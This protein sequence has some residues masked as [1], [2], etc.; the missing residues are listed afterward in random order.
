MTGT[1]K[2][3]ISLHCPAPNLQHCL[4]MCQPE[5]LRHANRSVGKLCRNCERLCHILGKVLFV[6]EE[7]AGVLCCA[8]KP[9]V[10]VCSG[11]V[12]LQLLL[13]SSSN[14]SP[15]CLPLATYF[16]YVKCLPFT[17]RGFQMLDL[18]PSVPPVFNSKAK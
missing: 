3:A 2:C 17:T 13:L 7:F 5:S 12:F 4:F 18:P 10:H 9:I 14:T 8:K 11:T 1:G 6:Y 15:F 16:N